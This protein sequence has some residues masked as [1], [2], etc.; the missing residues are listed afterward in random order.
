VFLFPLVLRPLLRTVP[1][2]PEAFFA[3]IMT[4]EEKQFLAGVIGIQKGKMWV[5][6]P[7]SEILK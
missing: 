2:N 7:F 4:M 3:Q 6:T 1:Y 5:T